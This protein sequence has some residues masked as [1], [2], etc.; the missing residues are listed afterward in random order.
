MG[1]AR[2]GASRYGRGGRSNLMSRFRSPLVV[3]FLDDLVGGF[4]RDDGR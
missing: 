4:G 2:N 1:D 3:G